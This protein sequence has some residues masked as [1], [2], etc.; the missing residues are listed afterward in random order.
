MS[1][2][3]GLSRSPSPHKMLLETSF[4]GTKSQDASTKVVDDSGTKEPE[5]LERMI[6]SRKH[7]PTKAILA[8]G[9]VVDA[10]KVPPEK[11]IRRA[12]A[13]LVQ[14]G[15][16]AQNIQSVKSDI[17]IKVDKP[18]SSSANSTPKMPKTIISASG[19][20][21][22]YIPLKGPLPIDDE[23]EISLIKMDSKPLQTKSRSAPASRSSQGK[24]GAVNKTQ[25]KSHSNSKS[26]TKSS[27]SKTA[28]STSSKDSK[29]VKPRASRP[30]TAPVVSTGQEPVYIRIKLKPDH[31]YTDNSI[32]QTTEIRKPDT[33]NLNDG[34]KKPT[35]TFAQIIQN[36]EQTR[37]DEICEVIANEETNQFSSRRHEEKPNTRI[38]HHQIGRNSTRS[39]DDRRGMSD[40]FRKTQVEHR[41]HEIHTIQIDYSEERAE[42]ARQSSAEI[43]AR[44][45]SI[46][47][48]PRRSSAEI[49]PRKGSTE[50]TSRKSSA[51]MTSR[52]GS[53]EIS[54]RKSGGD[55]SERK[56]SDERKGS[57]E[58]KSS[59]GK[60]DDRN[61]TDVQP[62]GKS[63]SCTPNSSPKASRHHFL[64]ESNVTS[65]SPSPSL[66][67]KS[68]FCSLFKSKEGIL[69]PESP[70]VPGSKRKNMLTGLIRDASDNVKER[71][72]SR[73][74]SRERSKTPTNVSLAPSSTESIDSK[75]KTK[76][77]FS[78]F[79]GKKQDKKSDASSSDT[80]PSLDGQMTNVKF[81]FN[82]G[83]T[84]GVTEKPLECDSIRIP[85]HSPTYYENRNLLQDLKTSSQ[86][87]QETVIDA[88]TRKT[89]IS[90]ET[91]RKAETEKSAK[92]NNKRDEIETTAKPN[93]QT[94]SDEMQIDNQVSNRKSSTSS[95]NMVFSTKLG[96][97]NEVFSTKLSK[98]KSLTNSSAV[99]NET[100]DDKQSKC[101]NSDNPL[102][103]KISV[104]SE[105]QVSVNTTLS[106]RQ[107]IP[108]KTCVCK[109]LSSNTSLNGNKP[110]DESKS[111]ERY[112]STECKQHT[113]R[114]P[115]PS[116]PL[117]RSPSIKKSLS[118]ECSDSN[119]NSKVEQTFSPSSSKHFSCK[120]KKTSPTN[121]AQLALSFEEEF[122]NEVSKKLKMEEMRNSAISTNDDDRYSSESER[123][124]EIDFLKDKT[125]KVKVEESVE[126]E[127]KGLVLQQD[128]FEDELPFIPTTLPQERS[129]AVPI[130]PI[131]QRGE[132]Y[133]L[134]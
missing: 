62:Q 64:K 120:I 38:D 103:S 111:D 81:T 15:Q 74:K 129:V 23:S 119:I 18:P 108:R 110:S 36:E 107:T 133:L 3:S 99:D 82:D 2:Q 13:K 5:E 125:Q 56:G 76:S 94:K 106:E 32:N 84:R 10:K 118:S 41:M 40:S 14:N 48:T 50:I 28:K 31:M 8:E 79:K 100:D 104:V 121:S 131:K 4:C 49:T 70:T 11:P 83:K 55:I 80:L 72:R 29:D 9:I 54:I 60:N 44:K 112:S 128:S 68:S 51:E 93:Y 85:L 63:I 61:R 59:D 43:S 88:S 116:K 91:D 16:P 24:T 67:R 47:I 117:R 95:G 130:I 39:Q 45:D 27:S 19:I 6:L 26:T 73:S 7:D 78:I 92:D 57:H 102:E 115:S 126:P 113:D 127:R 33:L 122:V 12:D 132:S 101:L 77:V 22:T 17:K 134:V 53:A 66:S 90:P 96:N 98:G 97:D 25:S 65:K 69:S 114:S 124:S 71:R 109:E 1:G 89:G 34:T 52:K 21:Y 35:Q 75:G 123:D 87:S 46:E 20:E 86:D 105:K 42:A 37:I 58:R 30:A